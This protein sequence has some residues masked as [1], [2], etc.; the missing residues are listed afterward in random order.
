MY[1]ISFGPLRSPIDGTDFRVRYLRFG[2][3]RR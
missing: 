2:I 1:T 3:R